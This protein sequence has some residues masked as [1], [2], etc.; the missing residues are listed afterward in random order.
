MSRDETV[1][2]AKLNMFNFFQVI[3]GCRRQPATVA[4]SNDLCFHIKFEGAGDR[5]QAVAGSLRVIWKPGL[6][7]KGSTKL[8]KTSFAKDTWSLYYSYI[9]WS[10]PSN[11][12]LAQMNNCKQDKKLTEYAKDKNEWTC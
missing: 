10:D 8:S 7:G 11:T 4:D 3:A 5:S 6:T 12:N 2:A 9:V 1:G